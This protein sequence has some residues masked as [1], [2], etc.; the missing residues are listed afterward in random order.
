MITQIELA[1]KVAEQKFNKIVDDGIRK[2]STHKTDKE[3]LEIAE[4][5]VAALKEKIDAELL[6]CPHCGGKAIWWETKDETYPYQ[7]ICKVCQCGTDETDEEQE[8][9]EDWNRRV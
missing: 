4:T 1:K 9:I 8:A 3:I 5:F 2:L 6:P 7:I